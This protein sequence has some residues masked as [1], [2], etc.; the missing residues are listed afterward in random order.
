MEQKG[1][2]GSEALQVEQKN[3]Q[4]VSLPCSGSGGGDCDFQRNA[5]GGT[6]RCRKCCMDFSRPIERHECLKELVKQ[7]EIV[8]GGNE[9]DIH[10]DLCGAKEL[11]ESYGCRDCD[12]DACRTCHSAQ[13]FWAKL[14]EVA[15]EM[16]V[17]VGELIKGKTD[18]E[19]VAALW[20][21]TKSSKKKVCRSCTYKQAAVNEI[22]GMCAEEDFESSEEV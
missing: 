14:K 13:Q 21:A 6:L 18:E 7:N 19:A 17:D 1:E 2:R 10:C 8:I 4:S 15:T 20:E 11:A 16:E 22:C 5:A 12:F 3:N 9:M